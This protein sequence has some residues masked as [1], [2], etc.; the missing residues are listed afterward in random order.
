MRSEPVVQVRSLVKRYGDED[1]GGRPRPGGRGGRHRRARPQRRGQDDHGR[2]L[3]GL[4]EAGLRHRRVLGLDPVARGRRA[5]PPDRRDAPVRRRLLG[6]PRRRDAPPR[7]QAARPPAGRGR[8]RSSAWA[9]AAAAVRPTGGSPAASSSG[10]RSRWPSSAAPNWS[11]WTSRPPAST[12][13]PAAPPGTWSGTCARTASRSSSPPTTWTRPSSSPTT[14]RS[15]TRGRVIAQG[16]PEEL[17]RGGAEN[18]LRFTGRPGLDV[19]SLLKALPGG[20]H[21]RRAD[22]RASYRVDRQGRPAAAGDR[23]PPGA[24]S[25]G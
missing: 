2:D 21:R 11:S 24:P 17:C 23:R 8:P 14:S 16:T 20:L 25:T 10:S 13:R 7:G 22:A 12:R 1:R 15:S 9:S 6:R 18:T 19:G 5:A 3:R 4:P